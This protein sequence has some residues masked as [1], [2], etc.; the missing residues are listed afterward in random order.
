MA[1]VTG[2]WYTVYGAFSPSNEVFSNEQE[3]IEYAKS[4]V[5]DWAPDVHVVKSETIWRSDESTR[6]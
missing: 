5:N 2:P 1:L 3:A 4:Q 6:K